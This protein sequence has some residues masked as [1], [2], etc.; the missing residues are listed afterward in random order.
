MLKKSRSHHY[1][2]CL[3]VAIMP[4]CGFGIDIY[5]P[6]LPIITHF[7]H[8]SHSMGKLTIA[9]Y[10]FGFG[11]GQ[12]FTGPLSDCFGRRIVLLGALLLFVIASVLA[13]FSQSMHFFVINAFCARAVNFRDGP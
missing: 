2:T 6:S 5:T 12:L 3:I 7:L 8:A 11:V 13:T 10:I 1:I 4:L 9:I